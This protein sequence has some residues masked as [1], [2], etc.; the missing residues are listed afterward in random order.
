MLT[1]R[2]AIGPDASPACHVDASNGS[3]LCL[4]SLGKAAPPSNGW[5]NR[6]ILGVSICR[7]QRVYR[8]RTDHTKGILASAMEGIFYCR[9]AYRANNIHSKFKFCTC[10]PSRLSPVCFQTG[11]GAKVQKLEKTWTRW[12]KLGWKAGHNGITCD[13]ARASHPYII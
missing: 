1:R 12:K 10:F 6:G 11:G 8:V 3:R 7:S 4:R 13:P 9:P 5:K 2:Q